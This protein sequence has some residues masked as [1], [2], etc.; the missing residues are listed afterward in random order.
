M[1][2]S[3]P[4]AFV[5]GGRRGIG[6]GCAYALAEK[7]FDVVIND[8]ERDDAVAETLVGIDQRGGAAAFVEG[9][10]ADLDQHPRMVEE[11][12]A[13]FG[14]VDCMVNN[15]GVSVLNRGDLLEVS[16]ESYDRVM[17]INVRGPFFLAQAVAKRMVAVPTGEVSHHRSIHFISSM[18][19]EVVGVD[20]GEYC[21]SKAAVAM[22]A[23]VYA[24]YLGEHGIHVY[25]I[26][27]GIIRTDMT[28]PALEKYN[29]IIPGGVSPIARWGEPED[30][31][32]AV[33][34]LA[35]GAIPFSTGDSFVI[36]GGIQLHR[37]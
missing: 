14:K 13:A 24:S 7:G 32:G 21:M 17:N 36:G 22:M 31:G 35:A 4:V 27:P 6:R 29:R 26:R 2:H 19:A 12:F 1:P 11:T 28:K 23:K 37:V 5:T 16:V 18:N 33:A 34:S 30:V 9:S 15:A 20:R 10:V 8:L 25:D 3:R